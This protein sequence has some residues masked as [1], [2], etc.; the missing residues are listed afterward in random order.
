MYNFDPAAVELFMKEMRLLS[1]QGQTAAQ[2]MKSKMIPLPG[3]VVA[4]NA[5]ASG[6]DHE[7]NGHA[8]QA[9][10]AGLPSK[11]GAAAD[12]GDANGKREGAACSPAGS[13]QP[14]GGPQR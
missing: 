2:A 7:G 8:N 12:A 4:T 10:N 6:D 11:E 3:I 9:E 5:H 14:R 1:A 13:D